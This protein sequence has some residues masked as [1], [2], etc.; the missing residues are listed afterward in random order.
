MTRPRRK[1]RPSRPQVNKPHE[2]KP[3]SSVSELTRKENK[4]MKI[5]VCI[6]KIKRGSGEDTQ[7]ARP[8]E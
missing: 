3:T 5:I 4:E 1:S 8:E 7:F 2:K 6:Y